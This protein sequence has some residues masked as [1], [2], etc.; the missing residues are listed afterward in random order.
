[1]ATTTTTA[2][3]NDGTAATAEGTKSCVDCIRGET[4]GNKGTV[5]CSA[6]WNYQYVGL[7]LTKDYPDP[8]T[9]AA[10]LTWDKTGDANSS[11]STSPL[12]SGD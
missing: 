8:K 5:W 7:P 9:A 11:K 6:G 10:V 2:S 12:T 4:S 1:M 3:A